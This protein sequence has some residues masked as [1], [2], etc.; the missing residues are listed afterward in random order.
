MIDEYNGKPR[1]RAWPRSRGSSRNLTNVQWTDWL[2]GV[3]FL[4]RYQPAKFQAQFQQ[5]TKGTPWM[6]RD[7]F[8][9][10]FRGRAWSF[11]DQNG[12][13]YYPVV[14]RQAV[15]QSLD[16]IGQLEGNMLYRGPNGWEAVDPPAN[17][18]DVLTVVDLAD[19]PQWQPGGGGGGSLDF[20]QPMSPPDSP[21][22]EDDEFTTEGAGVPAGWAACDHGAATTYA[23]D[24]AGLVMTQPTGATLKLAGI[25]KAIPAGD[26]TIWTLSALMAPRNLSARCGLALWQDP[27]LATADLATWGLRTSTGAS[28]L[29]AV[30]WTQWNGAGTN[31]NVPAPMAQGPADCWLRISRSGVN[32]SFDYS[33]DGWGWLRLHTGTLPFTPTAFGPVVDNTAAGVTIAARNAFFRYLPS[34]STVDTLMHGNRT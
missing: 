21:G 7:P 9:S 8:I 6:A 2:K 31:L 22:S 23:V 18:G 32:Y 26:F 3:T 5:A 4:Y 19:L 11:T 33:Y 29:E 28:G 13:T 24:K 16:A 15:S 14:A 1:I 20:W 34:A 17:V 10:G 30:R 25:V 12:R 27:A